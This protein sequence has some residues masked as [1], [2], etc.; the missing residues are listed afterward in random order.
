[1]WRL[2]YSLLLCLCA[3][4]AAVAQSSDRD[5]L[6]AFLEDNLSGAGRTV[7]VTGFRGAL[8][9]RATLERLTIADDLG[10]WLELNGVTLDWSRAA[11]LRGR[12]EITELVADEVLINRAPVLAD[13]AAPAPE[14]AGFA[15]PEL[16]VSVQ[17]GRI[18]ATRIVLGEPILGR[19]IEG[20]LE[21]SVALAGGEGR[22]DLTIERTDDGP[23]GRLAL[24]ASYANASR[25]LVIDLDASEGAGGIAAGLLAVPG[26]PAV[27]LTIKGSGP[28]EDFRADVA[29]RTD[30]ADRLAGTVVLTGAADGAQQFSL[31]LGGDLAPLFL[32]DYA[33]FFG[34]DVR[35]RATGQ[36]EVSGRLDLSQFAVQTHALVLDGALAMAA[37]GLPERFSLIGRLGV[38]SG[39]A[40]IL[41]MSGEGQTVVQSA[42]LR[43]NFDAA[44][45]DGWSGAVTITGLARDGLAVENTALNGSGR[46]NRRAGNAGGPV[47][48]ATL[49]FGADGVVI[50]DP[51]L[52]AALGRDLT[53]GATLSWQPGGA[54]L[55]IGRLALKGADYALQTSGRLGD[56]AGGLRLT[57]QITAQYDDLSRLAALAGRPLGG[58]ARI[59]ATGEGSP[60]GGDFDVTADVTGTDITTGIAELDRVLRGNAVVSLSVKRDA[61]GTVLRALDIAAQQVTG[62]ASGRIATAGSDISAD[63]TLSDLSVFGPGYAGVLQAQARLVGTAQDG[64]LTLGGTGRGLATGQAAADRMLAGN[65]ALD[66]AVT[67]KDGRYQIEKAQISNPQVNATASGYYAASGSDVTTDL[68][69]PDLGVLGGG[70][71][72]ALT[73]T[74]RI[75]GKMD[76]GRLVLDGTGQGLAIGQ[77]AADR[78]LAGESTVSAAL[79]LKSGRVQIETLQIATPQ[80][81]ASATGS[82]TE[83]LRQITLEARLANL[84]LLVPEFPGALAVSGSVQEDAQGFA[85]D[86]AGQGP[87]QIDARVSGRLTPDFAR[88]DL[89]ITG[90]AQAALANVFLG[91]RAISGATGFDLTLNGPLALASLAGQINLNGARISDPT[92]P[93]SLQ[94]VTATAT[95][96]N[97]V[98]RIEA[99]AAATTGGRIAVS[100][101]L[102]LVQ[103]FNA[104]LAISVQQLGLKDPELY[105]T[106]VDGALSLRG[107]LAGGGALLSGQIA[108][109]ET[110]LRVPSAGGGGVGAIP[111]LQHLNEPAAVHATRARAG[112][113]DTGDGGGGGGGA[114]ALDLTISAP[115]RVFLRGRGLDAELG[116]QVVLRGTT[117]A[118]VPSG[119]FDLIRGRLD[120]LGTRLTLT[121]ARLLLQGDLVPF[122]TIIASSESDGITS[123]VIIEGRANNPDVRFTSSPELPQE[124]VLARLL[125]GRGLDKISAFQAAQLA[126]AVST[127]A[128]RGG[129]GIVGKLRKGFGLD[130]LDLVTGADGGASV[131]AGKYLSRDLYTEVEV[132][133]LGQSKINLNLD[134]RK[135]VTLR[136][137]VSNDGQTGIGIFVEKD[138]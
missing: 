92:L 124:E 86:L 45:G 42:D 47:L 123:S 1:M 25:V 117:A 9:S 90:T 62:R 52:A 104:D 114:L 91:N 18:A 107:P 30:G 59:T 69:L 7:T 77:V 100:G 121:T 102:G 49:T 79:S 24:T 138:Y 131:K 128:G 36:R 108:L 60:L 12:I 83:D 115:N 50:G 33:E 137:H 101:S 53:G 16:P 51:A 87:G 134:L 136:G 73:A 122:L 41:P 5:L 70:Y 81:T 112:L 3:P 29:L 132:D 120:I 56:L 96:G 99:D 21:G 130:D 39:E 74:A 125:F 75:S 17:I 38:P 32:P 27:A 116:G 4:L 71:R 20:T 113:L 65:S 106:T 57:G 76:D 35:L 109:G 44:Q 84:A 118:L 103:P 10:V 89:E 23:D 98:M 58:A 26:T 13:T 63:F 6:T 54:G 72:G 11:V 15:L 88:A 95:L 127:L 28:L 133:Q 48:G 55:R 46:I 110:E 14:A 126:S 31:D 129:E 19:A 80:V 97:T 68:S 78:L 82:A 61:S 67:F 93:F 37:D 40:V 111:D 2:V 105:E 94:D 64:R 8:S 22:A 85:L 135:G 66:V 119:G 43:L 34:P